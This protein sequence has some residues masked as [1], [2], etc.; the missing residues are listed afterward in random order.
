M[1]GSL[2][3]GRILIEQYGCL[4][5]AICRST[6][7][8]KLLDRYEAVRGRIGCSEVQPIMRMSAVPREAYRL[9]NT[10]LMTRPDGVR[11]AKSSWP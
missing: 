5:A 2:R 3:K 4:G 10:T 9:G 1:A 7:S 6:L 8:V 11:L